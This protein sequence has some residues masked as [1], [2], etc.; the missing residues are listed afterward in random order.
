MLS[1][2]VSFSIYNNVWISMFTATEWIDRPRWTI[3]WSASLF[4]CTI[5]IGL[6]G[7]TAHSIRLAQFMDLA[8]W[9]FIA[10]SIVDKSI[11]ER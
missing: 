6:I 10:Q 11:P 2:F 4:P 1:F 3:T 8:V 9:P 5:D 7:N